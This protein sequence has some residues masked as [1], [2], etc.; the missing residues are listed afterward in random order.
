MIKAFQKY[1][2][3]NNVGWKSVEGCD[4]QF[5]DVKTVLDNVMMGQTV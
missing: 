1:L 2:N 3:V 5:E 4:K